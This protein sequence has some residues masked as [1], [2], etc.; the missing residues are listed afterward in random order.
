MCSEKELLNESTRRWKVLTAKKNTNEKEDKRK[1]RPA[2]DPED[3]D[4]QLMNKAYNLAEKQLED[5]TA[6]PSVINHF[7]KI[8]SRRETLEREILASQK[9]LIEAKSHNIKEANDTK[10]LV[11]DAMDAIRKYKPSDNT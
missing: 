8:A 10:K 3:R 6:S 4:K 11:E 7:L 1:N 9:L 2:L 5:G